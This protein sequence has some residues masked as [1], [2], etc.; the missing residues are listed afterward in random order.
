[1]VDCNP[2]IFYNMGRGDKMTI[3]KRIRE[4]RV[5]RSYSQEYLA[6]KLGVS[7]QAVS[8]WETDLSA[9]DTYNLIALSKLFGVSVEYI[10]IG[11]CKAEN[12]AVCAES[13][14]GV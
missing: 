8:K 9:P 5:S 11:E 7:R 12:E 1:M 13:P 10:A 14:S 3:G 2:N 4:L 6:E